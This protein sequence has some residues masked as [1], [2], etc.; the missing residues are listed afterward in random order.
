MPLHNLKPAKG[1]I[2]KSKRVGCGQG[3]GRGGTSTRGHNGA[4]SRSGYKRK[5][6]FEGGQQPLQRRVPK[7]GNVHPVGKVAYAIL[8]LERLQLTLNDVPTSTLTLTDLRTRG[9]I[10]KNDKVKILARGAINA[11]VSIEAHAF[12]KDARTAIE[13]AG[14]KPIKVDKKR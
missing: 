13:A 14:G 3:S 5:L 12:S 11:A 9:L 4:Q 1:A 10:S 7:Q 2:S 6:G 8:N